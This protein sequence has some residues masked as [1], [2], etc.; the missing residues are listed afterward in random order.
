M[1][2]TPGRC[3][4]EEEEEPKKRVKPAK[5]TKMIAHEGIFLFMLSKKGNAA[6]LYIHDLSHEPTCCSLF[7]I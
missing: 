1:E 4:K 2:I 3:R 5:Y 7:K 6:S